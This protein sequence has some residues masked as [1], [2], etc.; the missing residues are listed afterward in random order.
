MV[1]A[2]GSLEKAPALVVSANGL[3]QAERGCPLHDTISTQACIST[4]DTVRKWT[5]ETGL[6]IH[7]EAPHSPKLTLDRLP[8][9]DRLFDL[10]DY[11]SVH[12][13]QHCQQ[14]SPN[15]HLRCNVPNNSPHSPT[16]NRHAMYNTIKS[17]IQ[18][19]TSFRSRANAARAPIELRT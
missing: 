2:T 14:R 6:S 3:D 18:S 19:G 15:Q 4:N 7:H 11:K 9:T 17:L 10:R 8:D 5:L 13:L 12:M 16:V 1:G